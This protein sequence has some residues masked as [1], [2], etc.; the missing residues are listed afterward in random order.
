MAELA[1]KF[2]DFGGSLAASLSVMLGSSVEE[3][4]AATEVL[5]LLFLLRSL[6]ND[7]LLSN[8]FYVKAAS[9]SSLEDLFRPTTED[10]DSLC[11][12]LGQKL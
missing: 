8:S 10:H 7:W 2:A 9:G 12:E 6:L 5:S 4:Y 11:R 1:R 3:L